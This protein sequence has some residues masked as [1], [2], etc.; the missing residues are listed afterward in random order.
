MHHVDAGK[1]HNGQHDI[2]CR[3]RDRHD[4]A[5]PPR[6][7]QELAGIVGTAVH[8]ILADIFTYPPSGMALIL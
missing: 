7:I 1:Q 5:L 8:R 2:H 6:M 4:K 3:S